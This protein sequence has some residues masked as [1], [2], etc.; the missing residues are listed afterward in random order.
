MT[1]SITPM[2]FATTE[3]DLKRKAELLPLVYMGHQVTLLVRPEHPITARAMTYKGEAANRLPL[4]SDLLHN[5]AVRLVTGTPMALTKMD[6]LSSPDL[7]FPMP[8]RS[9]PLCHI[10]PNDVKLLMRPNEKGE[11]A[12]K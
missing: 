6:P 7:L 2:V 12:N 8:D 1:A 4:C 10:T 9:P 5:W 3:L 11:N